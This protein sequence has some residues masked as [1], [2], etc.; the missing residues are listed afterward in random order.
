MSLTAFPTASRNL[1]AASLPTR[2]AQLRGD[3]ELAAVWIPASDPWF[4]VLAEIETSSFPEVAGL[5]DDPEANFEFLVMLGGPDRGT[6]QVLHTMRV[7]FPSAGRPCFMLRDLVASGQ[8]DQQELDE[9]LESRGYRSDG[10]LGVESSSRVQPLSTAG[11][12]A[13]PAY[14][15]VLD[16]LQRLGMDGA[17]AH[18]NAA[19][20]RSFSRIGMETEPILLERRVQTP[21]GHGSVDSRYEPRLIPATPRVQEALRLPNKSVSR[22][23]RVDGDWMLAPG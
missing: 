6:H 22:I 4:E 15:M 17:V 12:C 5:F 19:A 1:L 18:Q 9:S 3:N 21:D 16:R 10:F 20:R 2:V 8:L 23:V 13:L 11:S 14:S 7:S